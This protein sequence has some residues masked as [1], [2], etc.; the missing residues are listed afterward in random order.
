MWGVRWADSLTVYQ[1]KYQSR[2]EVYVRTNLPQR[3]PKGNF[4][5]LAS[6][7]H[8]YRSAVLIP[9]GT[10]LRRASG[11]HAVSGLIEVRLY[12]ATL[13]W[14]ARNIGGSR[15]YELPEYL[16]NRTLNFYGVRWEFWN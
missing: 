2:S 6:V 5:F 1:P 13:Y 3:F 16:R 12:T 10:E 7:R 8:E 9:S 15:N 11:T 14:Q 4:S